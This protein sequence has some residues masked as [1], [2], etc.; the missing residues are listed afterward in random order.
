M[1]GADV[2]EALRSTLGSALTGDGV[3]VYGHLP[4]AVTAPAV[5]VVPG[6]PWCV[7]DHSSGVRL[8]SRRW[9]CRAVCIVSL[10]HAESAYSDLSALAE[11]VIEAVQADVTLAGE[12]DLALI[13]RIDEPAETV[14]ADGEY[15]MCSVDVEV[16]TL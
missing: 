5:A 10:R 15:L 4:K 7:F 14:I 8:V 6:A 1:T 9:N 13:E 16:Q 3:S 11:D 2:A 12:V